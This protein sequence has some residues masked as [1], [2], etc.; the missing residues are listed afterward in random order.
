M[1]LKLLVRSFSLTFLL[2]ATLA[3][4]GCDR[5]SDDD[6][7]CTIPTTNNPNLIEDSGRSTFSMPNQY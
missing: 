1:H 6:Y 7:L 5:T 2:A 4:S 3:L